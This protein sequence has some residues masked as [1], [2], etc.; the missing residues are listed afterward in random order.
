MSQEPTKDASG[1]EEEDN[2]DVDYS[3][4]S[5]TDSI[6]ESPSAKR[7]GK[8]KTPQTSDASGRRKWPQDQEDALKKEFRQQIMANRL[9]G[10][11]ACKAAMGRYPHALKWE[12]IKN[13]VRNIIVSNKRGGK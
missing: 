13:K 9:P 4:E 2:D 8:R 11:I 6:V 1:S 12:D 7:K 3:Q 10:M 5:D